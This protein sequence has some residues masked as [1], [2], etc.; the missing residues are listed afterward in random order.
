LHAIEESPAQRPPRSLASQ[1]IAA[2][3]H[4]RFVMARE[5]SSG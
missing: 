3:Q 5:G 4:G 2:A 1:A